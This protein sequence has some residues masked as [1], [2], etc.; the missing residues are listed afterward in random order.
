MAL[1]FSI[2]PDTN[3][4]NLSNNLSNNLSSIFKFK[5]PANM[6]QY[7]N[8]NKSHLTEVISYTVG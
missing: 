4:S 3:M 7:N 1:S 5:K 8:N 2:D 6:K